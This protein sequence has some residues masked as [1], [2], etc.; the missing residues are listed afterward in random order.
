ML[1]PNTRVME[2][3]KE[4]RLYGFYGKRN[5]MSNRSYPLCNRMLGIDSWRLINC[6]QSLCHYSIFRKALPILVQ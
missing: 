3:C 2:G 4:L 5:S 6:I 1:L